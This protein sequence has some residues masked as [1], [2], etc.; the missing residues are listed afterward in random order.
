MRT[1]RGICGYCGFDWDGSTESLQTTLRTARERFTRT[2]SGANDE[3]LRF[4]PAPDVWSALEYMGH[5]RDGVE[6]YAVR[7]RQTLSEDCPQLSGTDWERETE[8]R[9]YHQESTTGVLSGVGTASESLADLLSSLSE[10]DWKRPAI[11][12]AGDHRDVL[13][14]ARRAAHETEHHCLDAGRSIEVR[15]NDG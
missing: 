4:R 13:L 7:I 10:E 1:Q 14:L 11:G 15:L 5:A 6:W 8:I 12:S 3:A 9:R 2:I